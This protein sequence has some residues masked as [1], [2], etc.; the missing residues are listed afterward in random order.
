[1][2]HFLDAQIFDWLD[3]G[4]K[5]DFY[6]PAGL[7]KKYHMQGNI[8]DIIKVVIFLHCEFRAENEKRP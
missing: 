3:S 5:L 8:P 1:L 6:T 7:L 4:S 2:K